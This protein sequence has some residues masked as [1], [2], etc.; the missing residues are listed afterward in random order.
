MGKSIFKMTTSNTN[1]LFSKTKEKQTEL[2]VK[3]CLA[4]PRGL[5][6]LENSHYKGKKSYSF[7]V[8][9]P[10]LGGETIFHY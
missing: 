9:T 10:F 3:F 5:F 4:S 6:P 2:R 8:Q 7:P 1:S